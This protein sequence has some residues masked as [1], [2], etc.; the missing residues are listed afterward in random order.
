M[1]QIKCSISIL[2]ALL[3]V[4]C[5]T[6]AFASESFV[7]AIFSE[8]VLSAETWFEDESTRAACTIFTAIGITQYEAQSFKVLKDYLTNPSW[9]GISKSKK[10]IMTIGYRGTSKTTVYIA[11]I[12]PETG[13]IEYTTMDMSSSSEDDMSKTVE[14]LIPSILEAQD[15]TSEYY[16]NDLE[17]ISKIMKQLYDE[18]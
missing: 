13:K 8:N 12:T 7:S 3:V 14:S 11:I 15:A 18:W 1:K 16:E 5:S 2:L 17:Q 6:V 10:Q 4:L 9:I